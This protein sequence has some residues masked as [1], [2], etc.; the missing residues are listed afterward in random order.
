MLVHTN[1]L[2]DIPLAG[3]PAER[4]AGQCIERDKDA[5]HGGADGRHHKR[6]TAVDTWFMVQRSTNGGLS[7]DNWLGY[8]NL[9]EAD[10]SMTQSIKMRDEGCVGPNQKFRIIQCT[11]ITK[12]ECFT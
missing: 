8:P 10:K 2:F 12:E 7:W 4:G 5:D 1:G 6:N 11:V 3:T 9:W